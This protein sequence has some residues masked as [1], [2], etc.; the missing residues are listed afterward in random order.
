MTGPV[1]ANERTGYREVREEIGCDVEI[2]RLAVVHHRR[3]DRGPGPHAV[4]SLLYLASIT[5][6]PGVSF[7]VDEVAFMELDEIDRWHL[8]H[9]VKARKALS[10]HR[11]GEP[12]TVVGP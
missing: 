7:E 10:V 8:D 9:E 4:V 1:P 6:T 12:D 11:G 2:G 3:A 5:G